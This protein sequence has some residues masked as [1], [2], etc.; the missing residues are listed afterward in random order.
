MSKNGRK[1]PTRVAKN[2]RTTVAK[3]RLLAVHQTVEGECCEVFGG[4]VDGLRGITQWGQL[5]IITRERFLASNRDAGR[6]VTVIIDRRR[7]NLV[8]YGM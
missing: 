8:V 5:I 6:G 3:G 1:K 4:T 2:A 7:L